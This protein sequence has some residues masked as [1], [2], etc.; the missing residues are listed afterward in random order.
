M[1][2]LLIVLSFLVLLSTFS[3]ADKLSTYPKTNTLNESD[4]FIILHGGAN[5][6]INWTSL[7]VLNTL[8]VNWIAL[9][10]TIQ[11]GNINWTDFQVKALSA[12]AGVNW[13]DLSPLSAGVNWYSVANGAAAGNIPCYKS[14]GG[15]G[16]CT[17]SISGVGCTACQ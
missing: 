15:L 1:K 16:K 9:P 5:S 4:T 12:G 3:Y 10:N 7:K 8:G 13:K 11:S 2:N 6:Q 17:T 14:A